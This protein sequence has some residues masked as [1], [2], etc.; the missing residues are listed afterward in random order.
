MQIVPIECGGITEIVLPAP[1]Y[2]VLPGIRLGRVDEL[3]SP[4]HWA[5]RCRLAPSHHR[6]F[7][8]RSGTLAEEV[9]FCLLGG[10]GITA[11][12]ATVYFQLLHENGIFHPDGTP[13][14]TAIYQLLTTQ[15]GIAGRQYRYRF[16]K[17][18]A[19]RIA[20]ALK[21]LRR[22]TLS[23]SLPQRSSTIRGLMPS[24]SPASA[25]VRQ[26][27]MNSVFQITLLS[28]VIES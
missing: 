11:E 17:Q 19:R 27:T 28:S 13:S 22:N 5:I 16:P 1:E 4:A 7:V 3:L 26:P 18:R 14:E 8:T 10:Y 24:N 23:I 15:L 20:R 12:L 6:D 2:E 25:E 9:S 21:W